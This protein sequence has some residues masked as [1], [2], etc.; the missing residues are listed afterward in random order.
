MKKLGLRGTSCPGVRQL[1][2]R[3]HQPKLQFALASE[4]RTSS[5]RIYRKQS[6]CN[7]AVVPPMVTCHLRLRKLRLEDLEYRPL[8]REACLQSK[9]VEHSKTDPRHTPLPK[10]GVSATG[11]PHTLFP[12]SI[13]QSH[14]AAVTLS[15][16][17]VCFCFL[18]EGLTE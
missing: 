9:H 2:S 15:S 14:P 13:P 16:L 4:V 10:L 17:F 18:R 3:Q 6:E 8:R 1:E 7:L 11:N 5:G 12:Y